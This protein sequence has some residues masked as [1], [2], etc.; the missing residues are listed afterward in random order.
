MVLDC[1]TMS[2]SPHQIFRGAGDSSYHLIPYAYREDG[3]DDLKKIAEHHMKR[4]TFFRPPYERKPDT[5]FYEAVA[6]RWFYDIANRQ[7]LRV[8]DIPN[9]HSDYDLLDDS[10]WNLDS[11]FL[12]DWSDI[13]AVAQ[14][15]GI[16]T[17]M[18]DWSFDINVALYFAVKDLPE[19]EDVEHPDAVSVWA[20]DRSMASM[21]GQKIRYVVPK[22]CDNPNIRAQSGLFTLLMG[23]EPGKDLEVAIRDIYGSLSFDGI[24][25]LQSYDLS[26]LKRVN[27]SYNDALKLK[28]NFKR[29]GISYDSVFPG[30]SGVVESMKIQSGIRK[31]LM[32]SSDTEPAERSRTRWPLQAVRK[33]FVELCSVGIV[34]AAETTEFL[35]RRSSSV[36]DSYGP[37]SGSPSSDPL[38]CPLVLELLQTPGQGAGRQTRPLSHLRQGL[39]AVLPDVLEQVRIVLHL[40]PGTRLMD[41]VTEAGS[42]FS[43]ISGL[44]ILSLSHAVM[45]ICR[46]FPAL[47]EKPIGMSA[48]L[49]TSVELL[50]T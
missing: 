10:N 36:F 45:T 44:G 7:G 46:P 47:S 16:P 9:P 18:L 19:S 25:V 14:H 50:C 6:L 41:T 31:S 48:C 4:R 30:W 23:D 32:R 5:S 28:I 2:V 3:M 33:L 26:I 21:L 39:G 13:A 8:P 40:L 22:Y 15:Y 27:I 37:K 43:L 29:R 38:H 20:L 24:R 34:R 35:Q 49:I 17:R 1:T 12:E 42:V 11:T